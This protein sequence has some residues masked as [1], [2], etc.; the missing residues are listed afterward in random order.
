LYASG[1]GDGPVTAALAESLKVD[2][3][4]QVS[5]MIVLVADAPPHGVGEYEDGES[6]YYF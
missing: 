6:D 4:K 5:K 3:R 1:G 2:L